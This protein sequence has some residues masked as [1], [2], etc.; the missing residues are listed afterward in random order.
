MLEC[1]RHIPDITSE[2]PIVQVERGEVQRA[3]PKLGGQRLQ[4]RRKKQRPKGVALLDP[5]CRL[6]GRIA[7]LEVGGGSIAP[8]RP[9][10]KLREL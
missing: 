7:K 4:S 8:G 3:V 1:V 10:A 5:A 2:E 6:Q 9:P